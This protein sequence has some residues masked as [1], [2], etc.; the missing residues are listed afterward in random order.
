MAY[1]LNPP[2]LQAQEAAGIFVEDTHLF[3]GALNNG[4]RRL[5]QATTVDP[6]SPHFWLTLLWRTIHDL[7][8]D[9]CAHAKGMAEQDG[10]EL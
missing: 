8:S 2:S 1:V 7:R 9:Y 10:E 4:G 3:E 6:V 5:Q